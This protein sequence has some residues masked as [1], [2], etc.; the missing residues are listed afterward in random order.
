[1]T[2]QSQVP[3]RAERRSPN[4]AARMGAP[5]SSNPRFGHRG[6]DKHPQKRGPGGAAPEADQP[7]APFQHRARPER[8]SPNHAARMDAPES[9]NPR[10]GHRGPDKHHAVPR[11]GVPGAQPPKQISPPP[12][13]SITPA[14]SAPKQINPPHPNSALGPRQ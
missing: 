8:R 9:S 4:H 2:T 14:P 10:F 5:E 12:H 11:S 3:P 13:S 6:P 7:A 1:M